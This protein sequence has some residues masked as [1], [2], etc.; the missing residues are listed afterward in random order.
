[1]ERLI[2]TREELNSC[3]TEASEAAVLWIKKGQA[4]EGKEEHCV[5]LRQAFEQQHGVVIAAGTGFKAL[6]QKYAF[7]MRCH[8]HKNNNIRLTAAR[9][10]FNGTGNILFTVNHGNCDC[11]NG[12]QCSLCFLLFCSI[13]FGR[14]DFK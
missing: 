14:R 6:K 11:F 1:M 10:Q 4:I 8:V 13:R 3:C 2:L 9:T 7:Y 12:K 5:V